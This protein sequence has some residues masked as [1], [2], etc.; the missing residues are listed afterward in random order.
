[1]AGDFLVLS[2]LFPPTASTNLIF[3]SDVPKS[4]TWANDDLKPFYADDIVRVIVKLNELEVL[5]ARACTWLTTLRVEK[6]MVE[7]S[8]GEEWQEGEGGL[9]KVDF[10]ESGMQKDVRWAV[11]GTREDVERIVKEVVENRE[12]T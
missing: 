5:K 2:K 7:A 11:E 9:R 12:E 10:R 3:V 8:R 1:M 4:W 6:L